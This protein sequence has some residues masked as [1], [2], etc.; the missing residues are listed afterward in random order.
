MEF[1]KN[2]TIYA[3]AHHRETKWGDREHEEIIGWLETK[4]LATEQIRLLIKEMELEYKSQ[5][6][7]KTEIIDNLESSN[8][9]ALFVNKVYN[10]VWHNFTIDK[11]ALN[12][13]EHSVE[14]L[15]N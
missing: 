1:H 13:I 3:V 14:S 5:G 6:F 11:F 10:K 4:E 7:D 2:T 8:Y 9:G 15:I 12:K